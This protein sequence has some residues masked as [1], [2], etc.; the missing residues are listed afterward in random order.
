MTKEVK[1][2][3][4]CK[5]N[6]FPGCF[7]IIDDISKPPVTCVMRCYMCGGSAEVPV[8]SPDFRGLETIIT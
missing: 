7:I 5:D 6:E 2:C 4:Y 1:A 8:V 3:E